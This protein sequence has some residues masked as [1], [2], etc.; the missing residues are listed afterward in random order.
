MWYHAPSERACLAIAHGM[1]LER[2][3]VN[4]AGFEGR[5]RSDA[6][7]RG[8]V[9]EYAIPWRLLGAADAVP[10][11]GDVLATAWQVF[12]SD[13]SGQMW[14]KHTVEVRNLAEPARVWVWERAVN[15]GRAIYR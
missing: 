9:L 15:W 2:L 14:R 1:A 5:F 11:S 6:D 10:R 8:Y 4:P 3:D 12:W 7:G 13:E